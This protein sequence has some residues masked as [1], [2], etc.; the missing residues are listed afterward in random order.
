MSSKTKKTASSSKA[1]RSGIKTLGIVGTG[2]M[3][4]GIAQLA[5]AAGIETILYDTDHEAVEKS[6]GFIRSMYARQ[7]EKH[8][9]SKRDSDE[10]CG[11]LRAV[12]RVSELSDCDAVIEAIF[13]DLQAKQ[14]LIE[15]LEAV[16]PP[17]AMIATNTS[18]FL[19]AEIG[20]A[21]KHPDRV[22]GLHFFNPAP[23]MQ[24]VEVIGGMNTNPIYTDRAEALALD[25]GRKPV[26]V[27]DYS[28][29][30]VNQLGR[31]Y[32]LEAA[33]ALDQGVGNCA[34]IDAALKG[35]LGFPLGPCELMDLTGL[36][37][38]VP[39][40]EAIYWGN[41]QE[42]RYQVPAGLV[43]RLRSGL[44]GQ[45]VQH[46]FY[47]YDPNKIEIEQRARGRTKKAPLWIMKRDDAC[48]G[49]LA[50]LFPDRET[51]DMPTKK[52]TILLPLLGESVAYLSRINDLDPERAVGLDAMFFSDAHATLIATRKTE[53]SRVAGLAKAMKQDVTILDDMAGPLCQRVAV[54]LALIAADLAMRSVASPGAIDLSAQ[55]ALGHAEGPLSRAMRVHPLRLERV[56]GAI[57]A[58]TLEPR[59]RPSPWMQERILLGLPLIEEEDAS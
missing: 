15:D 25:L 45:K 16:L 33:R 4:R 17:E 48:D 46:G 47:D 41:G 38:T 24:L 12:A 30:L 56:R 5:A 10:A 59:F 58:E 43:R 20:S 49:L 13:E 1:S 8:K 37:V 54:Q 31:G 22:V 42:P 14:I 19:V 35:G 52:A 29:F 57:Y 26:R 3:G 28:G 51:G 6:I 21:A 50:K 11:R 23:L 39:A 55:L 34:E 32:V 53:R 9:I 27:A 7:V 40:S 36:D 44:L 2:T 18:S